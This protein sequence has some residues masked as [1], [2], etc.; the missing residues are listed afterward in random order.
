MCEPIRLFVQNACTSLCGHACLL[1]ARV[2]ASDLHACRLGVVCAMRV[3]VACVLVCFCASRA[4]RGDI[5]CIYECV[6]ARGRMCGCA[7]VC[8]GGGV[9]AH[10]K[11]WRCHVRQ[12]GVQ[13]TPARSPCRVHVAFVPRTQQRQSFSRMLLSQ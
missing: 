11:N 12:L 3:R 8:R 13:V 1:F 10:S 9:C 6:C 5:T 7:L 4:L 2:C